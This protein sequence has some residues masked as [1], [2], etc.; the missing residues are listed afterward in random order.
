MEIVIPYKPRDLQLEFHQNM[1]R[2]NLLVCHRR[3]G[4]S[5][6]AIN[7]LVK[8]CLTCTLERPRFGYIAP[9][10]KQAKQISWD[11]SKHYSRPIPNIKINEAELRIDYPNE[12]R[13]Q[14]FGA[15]NPDSMR[16][17]YFDGVVL[18]E[19]GDMSPRLFTEVVRPALSDRKG[20]ALFIGSAKGGT[21]FHELYELVK[22]D[23]DWYVQVYKA[24]ETGII[25]SDEL[26]SA[27]KLMD[28]D[29][30]NQEYEC[31]WT[32]SIKGAYYSKQ[33][34]EAEAENRITSVPYEKHLKVHTFWDLGVSDA[35]SIWFVQ[36]HGKEIRF[37]DYYEA[38]GEGLPHYAKILQDKGYIYDRHWAPHDIKVRELGSGRS[39]IETA[40]SLGINF[41]IA[42]N[43]SIHNG[44]NAARVIF[45]RCWFDE[46]RCKEGIQALRNY[47]KDY[48]E[49]R[50]EFSRNPLHDWSSHAADAFR[51]FAVSWTDKKDRKPV[52]AKVNIA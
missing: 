5:V 30:Y 26:S 8:S 4:K 1:K 27:R 23:P 40:R 17:L 9:F 6:C 13:L 51:Y 43:D 18:D 22:D 39:R 21:I 14:L 42:P 47:K 3:F 52:Q 38:E 37:I 33:L 2:W 29:E 7:Q 16:G 41:D 20:W 35:T 50:R 45:N 12:A 28:E 31:S 49:R 44:I 15:D 24:S 11:Y 36:A 25:D 48:N 46:K 10:Y 19:Y 32:A 34:I